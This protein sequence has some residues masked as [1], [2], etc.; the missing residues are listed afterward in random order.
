MPNNVMLQA[1]DLISW[2]YR[3]AIEIRMGFLKQP[4]HHA[5]RKLIRQDA[6]F[7]LVSEDAFKR[8]VAD[9]FEKRWAEWNRVALAKLEAEKTQREERKK[10]GELHRRGSTR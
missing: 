3:H 5:A 7:H 1:A 10:R 2:H 6:V 8:Q 9:L 4:L